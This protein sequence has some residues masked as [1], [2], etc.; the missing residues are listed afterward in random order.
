MGNRHALPVSKES[1]GELRGQ[2]L[3]LEQSVKMLEVRDRELYGM[4]GVSLR[5]KDTLRANMYANELVRVRHLRQVFSQSQLVLE[6][7]SMRMESL[8][9]LYSAFQMDPVSEA[10]RE[11]VG[12]LKGLSPEF[13]S[14][15]EQLT[16]LAGSTLK[17]ATVGFREP[18]LDEVFGAKNPESIA[19]LREVSNAIESSLQ[20]AFPEPP[21]AEAQK[22]A[23]EVEEVA[24]GY[25]HSFPQR[26][27]T[28]SNLAGLDSISEDLATMLDEL[29]PKRA[30]PGEPVAGK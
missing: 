5:R 15:I 16:R 1:V 22:E 13:V 3:K 28:P 12:D 10:I 7:I 23:G 18:A 19:I 9:D 29:D 21:A 17:E 24:Y 6:C 2:S 26:R 27:P 8:L 25:E 20:D 11:V 14:G 4:I 30:K